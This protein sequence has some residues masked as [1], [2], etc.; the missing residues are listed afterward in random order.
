VVFFPLK[1]TKHVKALKYFGGQDKCLNDK[2]EGKCMLFSGDTK[3]GKE[4]LCQIIS[5]E[6][7]M[8]L[9]DRLGTDFLEKVL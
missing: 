4:I 5:S 1:Q 7:K 9:N 6:F 2:M 8:V 3:M